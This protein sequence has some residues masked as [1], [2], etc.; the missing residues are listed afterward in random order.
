MRAPGA[1]VSDGKRAHGGPSRG[2]IAPSGSCRRVSPAGQ[3]TELRRPH[4]AIEAI[5]PG[6]RG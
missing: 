1:R 4:K 3:T 5:L 2:Q 6:P